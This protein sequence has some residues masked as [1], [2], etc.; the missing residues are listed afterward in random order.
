[1]SKV[2]THSAIKFK[3]VNGVQIYEDC[4]RVEN[5]QTRCVRTV[6]NEES[7]QRNDQLIARIVGFSLTNVEHLSSNLLTDKS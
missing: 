5:T 3:C 6:V 7:I 1:M 4:S 2:H